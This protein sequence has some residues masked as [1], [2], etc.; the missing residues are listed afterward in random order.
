MVKNPESGYPYPVFRVDTRSRKKLFR[1]SQNDMTSSFT[2]LGLFQ[3]TELY[4]ITG[5]SAR[6]KKVSP[7]TW[8]ISAFADATGSSCPEEKNRKLQKIFAKSK[9][10]L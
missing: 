5:G 8:R 3:I 6:G 7:K 10:Y 4:Y 2:R 9:K 1:W